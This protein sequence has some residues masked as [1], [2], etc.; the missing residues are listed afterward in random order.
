VLWVHLV[1]LPSVRSP[2][3][4]FSIFKWSASDVRFHQEFLE[5]FVVEIDCY[6]HFECGCWDFQRL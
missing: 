2:T 6:M 4:V 1:D 3:S 5:G